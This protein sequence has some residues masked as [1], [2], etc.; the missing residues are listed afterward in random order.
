M[1][2]SENVRLSAYDGLGRV[3]SPERAYAGMPA[4]A[5]IAAAICDATISGRW[6]WAESVVLWALG[7]GQTIERTSS[8]T[9]A[10]F[11]ARGWRDVDDFYDAARVTPQQRVALGLHMSGYVFREIAEIMEMNG[12]SPTWAAQMQVRRALEKLRRLIAEQE[13]QE[14]ETVELTGT[15]E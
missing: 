14:D 4:D 1:A 11:A 2:W 6:G 10:W 8:R 12:K 7:E 5:R 3:L 9:E 13:E 15:G